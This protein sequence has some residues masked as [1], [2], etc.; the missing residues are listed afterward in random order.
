MKVKNDYLLRNFGDDYIV[1]AVGEDSE[2]FNKLITLN[3][4]GAFIFKALSEDITRGELVDK[5]VDH[6]EIDRAT[7]EKDCD[8]FIK[9]LGDAGL[10]DA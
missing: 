3:S 7:A 4:V 2:D 5:I 6:Y 8:A 1:V 10:L 9:K